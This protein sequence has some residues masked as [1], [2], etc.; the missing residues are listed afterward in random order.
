MCAAGYVVD[1]DNVSQEDQTIVI[2][3]KWSS[4]T[5]RWR[6]KCSSKGLSDQ[7]L[8]EDEAQSVVAKD[9]VIECCKKMKIEFLLQ[10]INWSSDA[11]DED[12]LL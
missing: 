11:E 10:R 4:S 12:S 2:K 9:Q 5:R 8:Q 6:S 1:D 7:V 3:G